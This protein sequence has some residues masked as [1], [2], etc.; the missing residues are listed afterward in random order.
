MYE[1]DIKRMEEKITTFGGFGDT[2]HGGITR[3]SLSPAAIQARNEIK[4]RM[5]R[6]GLDFKTDDLGDI[7][8]TLPGTDP[9]AKVIMSGSHCDSVRQGGNYDGILGVLTAM[10][11]IETI[12]TKKI[13][14]RHPVQLVVWTN[15]EG[16][17]YEPA[18]MCSG[19]ICGKFKK[20]EMF[21]SV[22][23]DGSGKTFGQALSES[24]FL[25]EEKNRIEPSK[26]E[27]LVE[28]HIEQGPVLEAGGYDVG[29]VEGVVGMINYEFTFHGQADHA[30][31]FPMPYRKDALFAASQALLFLHE[32][33]DKIGDKELVYTTGKISC[34]PNI[35]TIIPD[36]VKFTLDVRHQNP[37]I[38]KKCVEII[39]SMP[40]EWANCTMSYKEAWARNTVTFHK[41]W[42][43]DV[44][45]A[46]Q[47]LGYKSHKMYSGAGH[48]A[49]YLSEIVPTTMIF[50]PS[51]G[52][53]SHC[54]LEYSPVE[55][56]WKGAN[57]LLNTI[58]EIDKK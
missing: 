8:C 10:E 18:M 23:K 43:D 41:E 54:E 4:L 53:H 47:K 35:H 27:A 38:I 39:K 48:D 58:L 50:V 30:G 24:G 40:K 42:V 52:G 25:G 21:A 6:L 14:H 26:T 13:P 16:A 2:G 5:T 12:V 3:F 17:L 36:E 19:I 34:H 29:V 56:C 55:W 9:D 44:E 11:V 31:T 49:Q 46:A 51:K 28:L 33:F 7:Y 22:A 20:E 57:V 45:N 15:E 37:E 32:E 1:C